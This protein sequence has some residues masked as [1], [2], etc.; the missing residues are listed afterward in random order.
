MFAPLNC[1]LLGKA[2]YN[3]LLWFS[4]LVLYITNHLFCLWIYNFYNLA[5]A[6]VEKG[7]SWYLC[8]QLQ[9]FSSSGAGRLQWIKMI[10]PHVSRI[11]QGL[12]PWSSVSLL[13]GPCMRFLDLPKTWCLSSKSEHP[14]EGVHNT[15]LYSILRSYWVPLSPISSMLLTEAVTQNLSSL[16]GKGHPYHIFMEECTVVGHSL[17]WQHTDALIFEHVICHTS[18]P[19]QISLLICILFSLLPT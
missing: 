7:L 18:I 5:S 3:C 15:F 11:F 6:S 4:I 14:L 1:C 17:G 10:H 12:E 19:G 8:Y 9:Q 13:V 2:L 16:K